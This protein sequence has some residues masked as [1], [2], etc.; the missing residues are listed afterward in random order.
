V[1]YDNNVD[2]SV[3]DNEAMKSLQHLYNLGKICYKCFGTEAAMLLPSSKY[4]L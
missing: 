3:S 2:V 4:L 1:L